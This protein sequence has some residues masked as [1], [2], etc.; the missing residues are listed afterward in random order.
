M[1][2]LG[3]AGPVLLFG[4]K[5]TATEVDRSHRSG[6]VAL[7]DA[8]GV[9]EETE[10]DHGD[11]DTCALAAHRVPRGSSRGSDPLP[12]DR[13]GQGCQRWPQVGD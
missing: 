5:V 12:E 4:R 7:C 11:L 8:I 13:I 2:D 10:V 1:D 9:P 6:K 3:D